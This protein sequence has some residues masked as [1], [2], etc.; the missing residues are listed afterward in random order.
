MKEIIFFWTNIKKIFLFILTLQKNRHLKIE[1]TDCCQNLDD[2]Y[3]DI[4]SKPKHI[5]CKKN[6]IQFL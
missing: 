6:L 3:I 1:L 4:W 2:S 5:F